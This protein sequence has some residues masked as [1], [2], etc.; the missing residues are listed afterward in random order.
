M[1]PREISLGGVRFNLAPADQGKPNAITAHGQTIN[2]PAGKFNR[3]YLLAAA[4]GSDQKATF[5]AGDMTSDLTIHEWTNF[6]GQWDDRIWKTTETTT[7]PPANAPP[8]TPPRI[9]TNI[10]GE[11]IGIRQGFIKRADIAWFAS[12]RHN[13]DASDEAYAYSYLFAYPIDLTAGVRTL[14]LP[15]N[16]RIRILA[17][18]VADEPVSWPVQPLYD[19]LER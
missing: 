3:V 4:V 8:G 16:E 12:H 5:R 13:T 6:V 11:V 1:L 14:T 19:T 7:P 15:D 10:Y 17:I 18:T 2:L 9:R